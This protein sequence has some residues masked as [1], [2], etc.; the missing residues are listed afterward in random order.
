MVTIKDVAKRAGVSVATVSRV[1]NKSGPVSPEAAERIHEAAN[2]LHYVPHGG[3]RSLIT[4]KTS[5]IGVLLPD[6]YGG[7]FSEMIRG[8]D[9]TA[10][11]HGYHLLLSG[12]H[13]RKAEM[14]AAMRA[15]RGRTDGVIAMSPHFD[16]ATL[17]ENL[18]PSLPVILL[19]CEARD[20]DYQV[21]AIDNVGGAE[22]MVR[23]LVKLGHRRIA[24]VMG[25][26]GHFDTAERL[27]GYRH[28]LVEAGITPDERYE[29]QGDFSEASGHRA[30]QELL[31][32]PDR[33][34]AIF[35]AND[36]MAI[37]G[38]AAVHDAGLRVPE[39]MTV[40]GFDDIPLAHYMSP[41][42][43]SVHVPVFEMGER[44]VTR[45]IAAL[46]GE[47]VSERRHERLPTRL[48]VRSSCAAPPRE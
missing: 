4:S 8:I 38:L 40:V 17:V 20:E 25:E 39:D 15:M 45:L 13:N 43:S 12:S 29:A 23:H 14:E 47:P 3:A 30:V 19:S 7:F 26:K 33:P 10:Q 44:A 1:L 2:A 6:L 11:H 36:S 22:A 5:T 35:C 41:P 32:L 9:Q 48:V 28:A 42:L 46:K 31:A 24:M 18:P 34:T 21:I 16:A 37:G 27:Q